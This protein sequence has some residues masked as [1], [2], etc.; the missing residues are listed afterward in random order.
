MQT[1]FFSILSS[2]NLEGNFRLNIQRQPDNKMLVS[3][4]LVNDDIKDK[5]V[6]QI[7]A[8]VHSGFTYDLDK[9]FFQ[10]IQE[11][12]QKQNGLLCNLSA[13]EKALEKTKKDNENRNTTTPTNSSG[14]RKK[15][16]NQMKKVTELEQQKKYGQAIAQLPKEKDFPEYTAEI[17]KKMQ[18]LKAKHGSLSFFETAEPISPDNDTADEESLD[19][20]IE[21]E[22]DEENFEEDEED[23]NN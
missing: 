9:G 16:D 5:S 13:H 7:P 3:V 1:N 11:P 20:E 2:L 17:T 23:D 8:L 22:T 15:F 14:K 10:S 18:E 12:V 19:E 4:L 6:K 21:E